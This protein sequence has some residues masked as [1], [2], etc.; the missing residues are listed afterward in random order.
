MRNDKLYLKDILKAMNKIN[1]YTENLSKEEFKEKEMI[2]D[3]V[4]RNIEIIGEAANQL[5]ENIYEK[6]DEIPWSKMIGLRNIVTH[7]YFGVDLNI[8]WQ[9]ITVNIPEVKPKIQ[10]ILEEIK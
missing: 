7:K 9:I 6:Y 8:I 2:V 3:A 4:L 10:K 1:Q 5:S